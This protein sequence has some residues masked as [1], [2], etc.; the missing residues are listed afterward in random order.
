MDMVE[1]TTS[2]VTGFFEWLPCPA[3]SRFLNTSD[4]KP[5]P[6]TVCTITPDHLGALTAIG[7]TGTVRLQFQPFESTRPTSGT[8]DGHSLRFL[9]LTALVWVAGAPLTHL[10]NTVKE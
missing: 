9:R 4:V 1:D 7:S 3:N 8:Y 5:L 6:G 10:I 2:E